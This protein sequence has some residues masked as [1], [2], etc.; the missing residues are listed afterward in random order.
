MNRSYDEYNYTLS[1]RELEELKFLFISDDVDYNDTDSNG[2]TF[3]L[4]AIESADFVEQD[5]V[6]KPDK[7]SVDFIKW[8]SN[9]KRRYLAVKAKPAICQ[10]FFCFSVKAVLTAPVLTSLL[11]E[12][13]PLV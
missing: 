8:L 5:G 4:T 13:S 9:V 3:L 7:R 6:L 10:K 12:D 1:K 11:T 2:L